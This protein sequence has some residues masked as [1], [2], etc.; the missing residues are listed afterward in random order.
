MTKLK[1]FFFVCL[2][3]QTKN[4]YMNYRFYA[5]LLGLFLM[6]GLVEA[7]N[8]G[9]SRGHRNF[10]VTS[11]NGTDKGATQ[12]EH[13]HHGE[14]CLQ[15]SVTEQLMASDPLYRAGV[16][17]AKEETGR[18]MAELEQGVRAT[19]PVYTIPVVFH[20]IHKGESVGTGTNISDAQIYSCI[21]ALNRDYRRTN[22]DGGIG[23]GAGPDTEIQ[24]CLAGFDEQ[25]NPHSGINRVNGT[26][27]SGYS[28]YGITTG[29]G[30]NGNNQLQVKNLSRWDNRYF[31]NVWVVSEIENNG[32]DGN[33]NSFAGGTLGFAYQPTNPVTFNSDLDGIVAINLCVGND[34]N[35]TNGYRL[36]PWGG[37]TNRTMTH[38]VGH[39]L[40]LG[41]TF[42]N[43]FSCAD[44]DGI[45][46]TPPAIQ[47]YPNNCSDDGACNQQIENYMDYTPEECQD[48]FTAG[49]STYMRSVLAGV[50]NAVVNTNNCGSS[51][52]NDYDAGISAISSPTGSLC[53]GTITPQVLLNNYGSTTLTS[54]TINYYVDAQTP[55]TYSWSG[56]LA[57]NQSETVTLPSVTVTSG[58]HT[59]TAYTSSPNNQTD[60]DGSND[61]A[62]SS[63][64]SSNADSYVTILINTD[65]YGTETTWTLTEDGGGTVASGGPYADGVNIQI[66]ED[67]CVQSGTC[68]TF[69]INDAVGDGICCDYGL[70]SYTIA[71]ENGIA[72]QT[73]GLFGFTETTQFCA[74]TFESNCGVDF[75]PL[76]TNL[77]QFR[78]YSAASGFVAGTNNYGDLAKAQVFVAPTQTTEVTGIIAYIGAK[79]DN[80]AT[81]TANLYDLDGTGTFSGGTTNSAPGTVLASSTKSLSRVD[82]SN[83]FTRF[84]F[85]SPI[86]LT[87]NY[88]VGLD[89]TG[90]G[91]GD[92]LGIVT[93][94]EGDA[95]GAELA[96]EKWS[97]GSWY[98]MQSSWN[99]LGDFDLAIFPTLCLQNITGTDEVT[100]N[101]FNLYPNP[102]N[103]QFTLVNAQ[104]MDG[105]L[106]IYNVVGQSILTRQLSNTSMLNINMTDKKSGVYVIQINTE[107][108]TWSER[109]I[110]Q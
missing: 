86:T 56:S 81:V 15:Q 105:T 73:G 72:L 2:P 91:F 27:V 71:D 110:V 106:N 42:A 20:I 61:S 8:E 30:G 68:Y 32:A 64:T 10:T 12:V 109:I 55:A 76:A 108:G 45:S 77:T 89:F 107:N 33:P 52:S 9:L 28:Q 1:F 60:Q 103:G 90:F 36:W 62:N 16:L 41:H 59:F 58:A 69:T 75:E 14:K 63:F 92:T 38:E 17:A 22:A 31:M 66:E 4:P 34:P 93:N 78:L 65:N 18:V 11:T 44:G 26:G 97:D 5:L 50:R 80:G 7:Q 94:T 39:Y 47:F 6:N 54:V 25:G 67:V 102:N 21:D 84:E 74:P 46:D 53:E 13:D 35:Q 24:F 99:N 37:L 23:Q 95:G 79:M 85:N 51:S 96:W 100:E 88:A 82:T 29:D 19:P 83:F 98:T 40:G 48:Q 70:G 104:S 101:S 43:S 49:Q 3:R 57:S 87:G